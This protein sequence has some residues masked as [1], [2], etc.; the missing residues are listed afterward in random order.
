MSSA[1]TL[2]RHG[3]TIPGDR[4]AAFCVRWQVREMA[5]FGSYLRDDFRDESDID[6][7]IAAKPDVKWGL[8]ELSHMTHELVA[9]LGRR[10]ELVERESLEASRNYLI[11]KH[12]MA[13]AEPIYVE[14]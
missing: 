1:I 13:T 6:L 3:I 4:I 10:V 2:D 7:L 9:L 8:S 14:G 5:V 12:I 11:R